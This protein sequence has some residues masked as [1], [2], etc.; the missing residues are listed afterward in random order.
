[1]TTTI[2]TMGRIF[3]QQSLPLRGSCFICSSLLTGSVPSGK[4]V[5]CTVL[6]CAAFAKSYQA[7]EIDL[8]KI[9]QKLTIGIRGVDDGPFSYGP[10]L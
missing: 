3:R 7:S 1:M 9:N 4:Y 2:G 6:F 10:G 8:L 5:L